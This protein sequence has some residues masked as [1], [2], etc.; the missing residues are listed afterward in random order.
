MEE[1]DDKW[2]S[3]NHRLSRRKQVDRHTDKTLQRLKGR[4]PWYGLGKWKSISYDSI[5]SYS[6]EELKARARKDRVRES[7][8]SKIE[9]GAKDWRWAESLDL[10]TTTR[11][12][13]QD[14]CAQLFRARK[15]QRAGT[16]NA[17]Q[18]Q[19]L[20]HQPS[21]K[22]GEQAFCI[23]FLLKDDN[24]SQCLECK[25]LGMQNEKQN[26]QSTMGRP[27]RWCGELIPCILN[28]WAYKW[29]DWALWSFS[30]HHL[31]LEIMNVDCK[32]KE[33]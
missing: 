14:K 2:G 16:I 31:T 12:G 28:S 29:K 11:N 13:L 17:V 3:I 33:L 20:S 4:H 22:S 15:W 5:V 19:M 23:Y 26:H 7:I 6:Y 9:K 8:L 1:L 25:W 18:Y 10:G 21:L 27:T 30:R 32:V 24:Y